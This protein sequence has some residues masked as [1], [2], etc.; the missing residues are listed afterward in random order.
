MKV[1]CSEFTFTDAHSFVELRNLTVT[2]L[3]LLNGRRGGEPARIQLGEWEDA[4]SNAWVDQQRMKDL[5]EV[6]Q[7]LVKSMKIAYMCRKGNN[8]LVT[9]LI[10]LDTVPALKKLADQTFW[11]QASIIEENKFLFAST[12][13]SHCHVSGWHAVKTVCNSLE[14]DLH[15]GSDVVATNNR[16]RISTLFAGLDVP[17]KDRELFYSHMGHSE[18]ISRNVYQAPLAIQEI[19]RVGKQLMQIDQGKLHRIDA[20]IR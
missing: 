15:F 9:V 6:D 11:K 7:L 20:W 3:T 19:N 16:H 5:D 10:P 2:R 13:P 17:Q 4:D 1:I 8:H 12:Q 14:V 18:D